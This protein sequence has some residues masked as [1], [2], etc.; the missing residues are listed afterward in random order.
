MF[1]KTRVRLGVWFRVRARA[2]VSVRVNSFRD[3]FLVFIRV[4]HY[5]MLTVR[6]R[7]H[8]VTTAYINIVVLDAATGVGDHVHSSRLAAQC[9]GDEEGCQR[10]E[11]RVRQIQGDTRASISVEK[12][13]SAIL[14]WRHQVASYKTIYFAESIA[15]AVHVTHSFSYLSAEW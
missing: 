10:T 2:R 13:G 1:W 14:V 4:Q 5:S 15:E 8:S 11:T 7:N 12:C 9:E 3:S 6:H